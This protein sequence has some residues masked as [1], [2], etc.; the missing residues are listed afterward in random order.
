MGLMLSSG[1]LDRSAQPGRPI[2]LPLK[3]WKSNSPLKPAEPENARP[4][5]N[6]P[7]RPP[8]CAAGRRRDRPIS[9]LLHPP[10]PLL[11]LLYRGQR[12]RGRMG[13]LLL[14]QRGRGWGRVG[15]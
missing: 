3:P 6:P 4:S 12:R 10:P 15:L 7:P 9:D 1:L 14:P 13:R 8:P 11:L 2:S 5:Q